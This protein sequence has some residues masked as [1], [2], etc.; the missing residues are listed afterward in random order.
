MA[1]RPL[2]I[3]IIGVGFG[4]TVHIPGLQSEGVEVVAVCARREERARETAAKFGIPHVFTDYH[5]MLEMPGLDA[6]SIVSPHHLHREM[7]EAALAAGVH[8]LC[9]KPFA[10]NVEEARS[11]RDSA[12][13]SARTAMLGHEFRWAPQRAYVKELLDQGYIGTLHF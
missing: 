1:D 4:A 3:G 12:R 13:R 10:L 8:V 5:K 2:R 6:V 7:A 11:M 9:E